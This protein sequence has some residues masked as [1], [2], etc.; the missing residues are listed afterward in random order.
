MEEVSG[1]QKREPVTWGVK[2]KRAPGLRPGRP[3]PHPG[4]IFRA[5]MSVRRRSPRF[6]HPTTPFCYGKPSVLNNAHSPPSIATSSAVRMHGK[7]KHC[8]I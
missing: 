7:H 4:G 5:A 1:A 2:R 3:P 8:S 6:L